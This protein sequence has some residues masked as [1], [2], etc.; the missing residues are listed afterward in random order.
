MCSYFAGFGEVG[1]VSR[2]SPANLLDLEVRDSTQQCAE[3]TSSKRGVNPIEF[4]KRRVFEILNCN[5]SRPFKGLT[6]VS[7][8]KN[9]KS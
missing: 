5:I 6:S 2:S 7:P 3:A 9:L 1:E 8:F 4:L